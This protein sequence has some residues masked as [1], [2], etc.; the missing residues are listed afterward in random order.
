MQH[1][2]TPGSLI[3]AAGTTVRTPLTDS[4]GR[5]IRDLRVSITDRCNY[6]CIYCRT[7]NDGAQYAELPLADYLRMVRAFVRLGVEKVRLTGGEPLLRRGLVEF[8]RELAELRTPRGDALDLALTTNGHLLE[9]MA[10]PLRKAG[11]QR[12]TVSMDAVEAEKFSRITRVPGSFER[13]LRGVE[14]AQRAGLEPVKVN[15]VVLRGF[16][17][18]QIAPFA[19]FARAK[20]VVVRFIEFM[21]LEEDRLWTPDTVVPYAEVVERLR[22]AG[23]LVPLPETTPGETA[24]RFG[25]ED[26]KGEV[27]I[28]APVSRSFC[29]AC[30][31][32][33]LTSDGKIRTCLFSQSE[34]D[35][36]GQMAHGSTDEELEAYIARAIA[37]KEARHHIGEPGFLKPSRS[38]VHIGG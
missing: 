12:I 29:G 24:V 30:S 33:R 21:P 11:L 2:L 1:S 31:R 35:L 13:V 27:G 18:D 22:T 16:N 19:E 25:F 4:H 3:S 32:V 6:R 9:E 14:A 8:V 17:D 15:C 28:I 7:G 36:Y 10:E 26:G 20:N 5:R 38:M 37:G 34:H 23:R